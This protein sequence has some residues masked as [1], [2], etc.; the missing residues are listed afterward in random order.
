MKVASKI[1]AIL[2]SAILIFS[3][4]SS[5]DK[6]NKPIP[7]IKN[8]EVTYI[9]QI[10]IEGIEGQVS[11]TPQN[12]PKIL[13]LDSIIGKDI[14]NNLIAK[15]FQRGKSSLEIKGLSEMGNNTELK[16]FTL[17][18]DQN[19]AILLG[20]CNP[21]GIGNNT[22]LSDTELSSDKYTDI[23]KTIFNNVG[24]N[25]KTNIRI[26]FTPNK[27]MIKENN[28]IFLNIKLTGIY[29]YNTYPSESK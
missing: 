20:N 3:A 18:I 8:K 15:E 13:Y 2:F 11:A 10:P 24:N 5:D 12:S 9:Y 4:C 27:T 21:T 22:F 26:S 1:L 17:F 14:S 7:I 29:K 16:D 23:V 19:P 6:D 28:K 25:K